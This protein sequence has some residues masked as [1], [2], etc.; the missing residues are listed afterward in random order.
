[1][2]GISILSKMVAMPAVPVDKVLQGIDLGWAGFI[3]WM[4]LISL[5]LCGLCAAFKVKSKAPAIHHSHLFSN[6]FCVDVDFDV[7]QGV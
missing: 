1:M 7:W 6:F 2:I 5:V 3:L 4:P